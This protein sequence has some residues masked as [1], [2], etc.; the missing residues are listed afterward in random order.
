MWGWWPLLLRPPLGRGVLMLSG[1]ATLRPGVAWPGRDRGA[2]GHQR[3]SWGADGEHGGQGDDDAADRV[4]D[5]H[6][7]PLIGYNFGPGAPVPTI[8]I[9]PS[10]NPETDRALRVMRAFT[11]SPNRRR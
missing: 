7:R 5:G 3:S 10:S 9:G 4:R 2:L 6:F 8:A 11:S 1:T